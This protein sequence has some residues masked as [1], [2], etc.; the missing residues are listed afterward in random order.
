MGFWSRLIGR[1]GMSSLDL[2][3][4]LFGG[5]ESKAGVT[6]GLT[7]ALEVA[8]VLA[9]VRVLANGVS[10]V[11][12]RLYRQDGTTRRVADDHPVHRL[13]YRRPNAW[14]TS[15]ELRQT[16]MFHAVLAGNAYVWKGLVGRSRE[17]R[18]LEPIEPHRVAVKRDANNGALT[19]TVTADDGAQRVFSATEIWHLRGPSW[20]SWMGM[21]SIKLARN[22]IG[23]SMATE[24]A[25]ANMHRNGAQVGGLLAMTNKITPEKFAF[26]SAWLDRHS[27]GGDR[28]G[29]PLILDDGAKYSP[30]GMTGV[31]AQHLETRKHQIEEIC[32][33]FG[34]M[35][36]M[37]G[38][39]DKTAT[40]ASAEQMFLAHVVHSLSPWYERIEQSADV[41]LLTD[42]ERE[43]GYYTKFTPNALMRGAA[44]DRA[45]FYAKALGSGG[46]KGWLTQNEVR[47]LEEQD[48]SADPA[49]AV[50]P[51]PLGAGAGAKGQAKTEGQDGQV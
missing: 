13:L 47:D 16:M 45:E 29:K 20:S 15:F 22:A 27:N 31:D 37:V 4:E 25:H 44:Q 2:F 41:N 36:I 42:L 3:R 10:Q 6:V 17:L 40:Y 46:G 30:F 8:T 5:R 33:A 24:D 49:A 12:F 21:D 18:A 35:P 19:Y 28:A 39:A 38:H 11:P 7:Q 14:Q 32:R 34:V 23:L 51:Q 26:L 1:K 50:L 48:P 9:C 43:Q